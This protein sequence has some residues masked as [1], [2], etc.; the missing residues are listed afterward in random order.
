MAALLTAMMRTKGLSAKGRKTHLRFTWTPEC[1]KAFQDLKN[2]FTKAPILAHFTPKR[3]L[4][5]KT[6]SSDHVNAGILSQ[7]GDDGL[8]HP[9]TFY[10]SKLTP[11]ECNYEIYDKELLAIIQAFEEFRPELSSA[12]PD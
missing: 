8:L 6:D 3:Q 9:V 10:S 12:E 7:I 2:A 4:Y 11:Q 5:L 1:E